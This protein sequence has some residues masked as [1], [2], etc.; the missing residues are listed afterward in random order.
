MLYGAN[1]LVD[2]LLD[3][4]SRWWQEKKGKFPIDVHLRFTGTG[5]LCQNMIE[6][7]DEINRKFDDGEVELSDVVKPGLAAMPMKNSK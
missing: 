1:K 2:F 6:N 4:T 5:T 3:R 7:F